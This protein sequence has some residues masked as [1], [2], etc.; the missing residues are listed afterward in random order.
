MCQICEFSE[1]KGSKYNDYITEI[2]NTFDFS[3]IGKE[4]KTV[5]GDM[6]HFNL[7]GYDNYSLFV[8]NLYKYEPK[9][10]E[11]PI[12]ANSRKFCKQLYLRTQKVNNYLTYKEVQSLTN[13]GAKYGVSDILKYCGNYTTDLN[14]T[15]CRHRFV[16]YKY[17]MATEKI[18][19]D[20]KQPGYV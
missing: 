14:Y 5:S 6:N 15:N 4:Y 19:R 7:M 10:G 20:T 9:P 8:I 18:V 17:D 2:E 3:S 11:A 16:R 13:P 12:Q 1:S